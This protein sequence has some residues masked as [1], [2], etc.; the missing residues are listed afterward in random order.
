MRGLRRNA[1]GSQGAETVSEAHALPLGFRMVRSDGRIHFLSRFHIGGFAYFVWA[2][3]PIL[4]GRFRLMPGELPKGT[5][6]FI[7]SRPLRS[8]RQSNFC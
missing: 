2:L 5:D 7:A 6:R 4:Y 8:Q 1:E 3:P